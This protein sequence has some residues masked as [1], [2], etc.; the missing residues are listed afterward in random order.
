[1]PII[2][3]MKRF[4]LC[5]IEKM[6]TSLRNAVIQRNNPSCKIYSGTII[7][8]SS[9]LGKYVVLFK[10]VVVSNSTIDDYSFVQ[11]QSMINNA[12]IGRFCSIAMNVVVGPGQHSVNFVSSHPSFYSSSQPVA[13]TFSD[14]EYFEPFKKVFIGNDVWIGQ[15]AVLMDGIKVGNGV[16]IATGAVVTKDVPDYA[17]VGGVPARII[18]YR[19]RDDVIKKLL[20]SKWWEKD[21]E[22]F[23]KNAR[24]FLDCEAFIK[25]D[26]K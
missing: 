22:W 19:F 4:I 7:D 25:N 9:R 11:K 16:V 3:M 5:I 1:M 23:L 21:S 8:S 10:N 17:I 15:N 26:I 2:I 18:R 20:Q 14:K 13:K 12:D 6:K 24:Q